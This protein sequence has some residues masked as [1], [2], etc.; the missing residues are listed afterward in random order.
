MINND[1]EQ[2][3]N[4][5]EPLQDGAVEADAAVDAF[6]ENAA[7]VYEGASEAADEAIDAVGGQAVTDADAEA[8]QAAKRKHSKAETAI[9]IVLWVAIAVLLVAVI[10][11]LF[12]FSSVEVDGASMFPTYK[13]EEVVTVNKT[14][15]PKRG[16]VAVFYLNEVE[17]KF[18]AQ[19]AKR[20]ECGK[21]QPYEK[22]IKRVVALEG[23]KIWLERVS[24]NVY[25]VVVSPADGQRLYEVYYVRKGEK[26]SEETYY[27]NVNLGANLGNLKDC[28][29]TNPFVV[30]KGCFFAM[31]DNRTVS[32]DSRAFGEFKL[33]QMFGVVLDM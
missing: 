27:L 4:I 13:D 28:T 3:N 11:R 23:D 31:G 12:V 5:D 24:D 33:S 22:L 21:G 8:E 2:L 18:L 15:L 20:E 16:D 17:N 32:Q 25:K 9:N 14:A 29:E 10:L 6:E 26:L 1:G 19:F 30:S 7:D